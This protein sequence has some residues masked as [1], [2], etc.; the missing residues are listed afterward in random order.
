MTDK[1]EIE[2]QAFIQSCKKAGLKIRK[3]PNNQVAKKL[4]VMDDKGFRYTVDSNLE[5]KPMLPFLD[6]TKLIRLASRIERRSALKAHIVE[7]GKRRRK[8]KDKAVQKIKGLEGI[9][10][11][12]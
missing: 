7:K 11:K 8:I 10:F 5:L 1:F 2:R 3:N 6:T 4:V 12:I 9:R